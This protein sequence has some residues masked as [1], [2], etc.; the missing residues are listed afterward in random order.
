MDRQVQPRGAL[1][2]PRLKWLKVFHVC[3]SY[4]S[5]PVGK[6][7]SWAMILWKPIFLERKCIFSHRGQGVLKMDVF[8]R[9]PVENL[10]RLASL[11]QLTLKMSRCWWIWVRKMRD[12][13]GWWIRTSPTGVWPRIVVLSFFMWPNHIQIIP[14]SSQRQTWKRAQLE[15]GW[16]LE[17][18]G[19]YKL[20]KKFQVDIQKKLEKERCRL[21]RLQFLESFSPQVVEIHLKDSM[22]AP[23]QVDK[24]WCSGESIT[25]SNETINQQIWHHIRL[26]STL[27]S[28]WSYQCQYERE[29]CS[30]VSFLCLKDG[31]RRAT[32]A[33]PW[34][35][36]A[37][38]SRVYISSEK[39][40]PCGP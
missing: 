27:I 40:T 16:A 3:R 13:C 11:K 1:A 20:L 31:I 25:I 22:R 19:G 18:R 23:G 33:S 36:L 30:I 34:G 9:F 24:F 32:T 12:P 15:F 4:P 29:S 37:A 6:G 35:R 28:I 17:M 5:R 7:L 2:V 10:S 38:F 14:T 8:K 26:A 21:S 39:F